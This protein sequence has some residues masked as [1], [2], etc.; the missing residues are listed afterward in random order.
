MEAVAVSVE[1]FASAPPDVVFDRFGAGPEAG[2]LFGAVCDRVTAG[3]VVTLRPPI[4]SS[5]PVEIVGR[6][7]DVRRPHA[8]TITHDLPWRGRIRLRFD[9]APGGTRIRLHAEIDERGLEWLMRR[10]GLAV[11]PGAATGPRIGLI[12]SRSGSGGLF[13]SA[14]QNVATLAVEEINDDGGVDGRPVELLVGD[15]ATDPA[16]GALEARRLVRAGCR[17]IV[18]MTTSATYDAVS[19]ALQGSGV[20]VVQPHM[21]EGGGESRLRL[22]FGERPA[23]QLATAVLPLQRAAGGRRWFLAGNDYV[24]PRSVHAAARAVLP[25]HGGQ[26]VGERYAPLGTTDFAPIVEAVAASGAD[27]VL[28]TFV[29]ADSAAF[30]RECHAMGL[31]DRAVSLAP[32]IDEATLERIGARAGSGIHG[33]S[34]YFQHLDTERNTSLLRRYRRTFGPWAPPLSSLSESVFEAIHMWAAAARRARTTEP[35]PVADAMR[36][37]RY[38]LPRGTVVLDE[39]DT[40]AP[41]LHLAAAT[42]ATFGSMRSG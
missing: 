34:G 9:R 29:G 33:V 1:E 23:A 11:P 38:E 17:V 7:S 41:P 26:L 15:D 31:R 2:W 32:A 13:A 27:I 37:G 6:I 5:G 14:S 10:Q 35:G 40:V 8:L 36:A 42:G 20:L 22:R 19:A 21:N 28:N 3:A 39:T 18:L 4:G 12:S 30:E 24:W 16:T 25:R